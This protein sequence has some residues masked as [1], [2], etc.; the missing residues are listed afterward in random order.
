[1]RAEGTWHGRRPGA[2]AHQPR[3]GPVPAA[4][5]AS[6]EAPVTKRELI[7]YF[8]RIA[9]VML[10]HLA[11]RPLNLQRFPNGAGAPGFWQKDIPTSAP[12]LAHDL[13]RDGLPR[14]RGPRPE[15]PPRRGPGRHPV[16]ARQPGR[17]RDPRLDVHASSDPWTPTFALIDIDPGP[18]DHVGRDAAPRAPL[19]DGARAPRRPRVPQ[20]HR[21]PRHPGVDPGRARPLHVRARRRAWV[22]TLSR[23]IGATV[24]DLVSWE[25]A[26]AERGGR[27]RLDYT[28]NAPIKTL[29]APYAVRPAARGAGVRADPL[30]R[31]GR[32]GAR[33]RTAG[34]SGR[35]PSA[36]RSSVTCSRRPRRTPRCCRRSDAPPL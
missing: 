13:A 15:R 23:A 7:G 35:C 32:P 36:S 6:D 19:P 5:T 12:T 3:Q 34:R 2:E 4:A 31:A 14:A 11:D 25:W 24:P 22:E 33:A 18:S 27:A 20:G 16:L 28:Q 17:V 10:P 21:Q 9:P 8:A 26:K 30:G 29:V 1:M